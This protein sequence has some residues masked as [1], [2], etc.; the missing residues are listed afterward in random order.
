MS[1]GVI[2]GVCISVIAVVAVAVA[3]SAFVKKRKMRQADTLDETSPHYDPTFEPLDLSY[4]TA[5]R[6][7]IG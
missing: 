4:R 1:G 7:W 5:R 6:E 3:G 2:A